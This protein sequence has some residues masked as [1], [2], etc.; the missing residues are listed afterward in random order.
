MKPEMPNWPIADLKAFLSGGWRIDRS[1]IDRRNAIA[2]KMLGDAHFSATGDTLLYRERGTLTFGAHQGS[3][4]Q[5]YRFEFPEGNA[6]ASVYFDDGR[7]FH[8]L[9]LTLGHLSVSHACGPDL[10]EGRFTSLDDERWQSVWT[11]TGPRKDQSILT[12]YSKIR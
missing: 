10:Y 4:E 7:E 5:V 9:D 3:A 1:L 12:L 11:V 2:G 6:R 8:Q